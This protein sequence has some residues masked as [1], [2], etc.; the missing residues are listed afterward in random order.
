MRPPSMIRVLLLGA[1]LALLGACGDST[2][3]PTAPTYSISGS[4]ASAG[5]G[6][7][8]RIS[9]PDSQTV[10]TDAGGAFRV[11]G[12]RPGQ[13]EVVPTQPGFIFNPTGI[14]V[15]ITD[16]DVPGQTFTR[17][18]PEEGLSAEDLSRIDA[19]PESSL[20]S[21]SVILPNGQ[22]LDAYLRSR[23][24]PTNP[25][26]PAAD[27]SGSGIRLDPSPPTGPQQR[28]NDIVAQM[29]SSARDFA[30]ARTPQPCTKWNYPADPADPVNKP[31]QT[32]LTYVYGGRTPSVR[33]KPVDGCPQQTYGMDC[34]GL[35]IKIAQVAGL[36]AP[37]SS[38]PQS[39]PENWKIPEE[40]QLK[41][42][43]VTDGAIESGDLVAWP[44][45]IGIAESSGSGKNVNVISATG[46]PG[47][48]TRNIS[49]PRG[50]RSLTVG[51]LG[52][53]APTAVLRLVTT[54][55][56]DF[57]LYIRCTNQSTDAAVI[58]FRINNDQGGPFRATGTGT[59]YDGTPLSFVLEGTYDQQ[60]NTLVAKL[61]LPGGSRVDE[62]NVRLLEDDTG[63]FT[64]KKVV[65][66][67]GCTA[68]GRLV[69]VTSPNT[70]RSQARVLSPTGGAPSTSRLG[71]PP[72]HR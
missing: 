38:G 36:T 69:R 70:P 13:Y 8:I 30:C 60:S 54:L 65:D 41:M 72:R 50:P 32:G 56:G 49:P 22:S 25:N 3:S 23:G 57:D 2:D 10:T 4:I 21:G 12:L 62:I 19:A 26:N 39:I 66:N 11:A 67:G 16:S 31:S 15:T 28:K 58:R 45:H 27:A 59:D 55:S 43:L 44:G 29:L 5:A 53:G 40:W 68:S 1:L 63:Y 46:R 64:M 35:I 51:A 61:S 14:R 18:Q 48:C 42:K 24:L 7:S 71:G 33:T 6:V 9:G 52:R 37:A 17:Q 20:P 34:S 47:E